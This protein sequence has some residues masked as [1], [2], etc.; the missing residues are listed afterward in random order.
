MYSS[1]KAGSIK[2]LSLKSKFRIKTA[3]TRRTQGRR[4]KSFTLGVGLGLVREVLASFMLNV[5]S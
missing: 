4:V 1:G 5:S 3:V 2:R